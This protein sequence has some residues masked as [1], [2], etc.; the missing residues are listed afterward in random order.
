MSHLVRLRTK[1]DQHPRPVKIGGLGR[2]ACVDQHGR[3]LDAI[4]LAAHPVDP[5]TK[6]GKHLAAHFPAVQFGFWVGGRG[7]GQGCAYLIDVIT[8]HRPR[9]RDH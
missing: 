6:S 4:G 1:I 3:G 8:G 9:L 7:T 5:A 2:G